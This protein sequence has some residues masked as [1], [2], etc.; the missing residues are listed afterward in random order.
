MEAN[1]YFLSLNPGPAERLHDTL[2]QF[3]RHL[4]QGELIRYFDGADHIRIDPGLIG[5]GTNEI[6]RANARIFPR[7][8]M[9][10]GHICRVA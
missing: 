3:F 2:G 1:G 6:S 5:N 9:Q 4:H 7:A 10:G 8:E